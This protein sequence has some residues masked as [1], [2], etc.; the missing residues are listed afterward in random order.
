MKVEYISLRAYE[1]F[2][3]PRNMG[4]LPDANG[5]ARITGPCGDTVEIRLRV[6]DGWVRA[7][8]FI[9]TGCGPSRACGSMATELIIGRSIQTALELE[10]EDILEE[11][12]P[13][14][15]SSRHC[16]LLAANTVKA[17][18]QDFVQRHTTS[19]DKEKAKEPDITSGKDESA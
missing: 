12:E 18:A 8:T 3:N 14:P 16:A 4:A 2:E 5:H 10:Q 7:A 15:E 13:F 6:E 17:A 9:T 1:R 19:P 11:L